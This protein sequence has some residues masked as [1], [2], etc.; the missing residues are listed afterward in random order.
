MAENSIRGQVT[1]NHAPANIF[2][3]YN[4]TVYEYIG[5]HILPRPDPRQYRTP[6]HKIKQDVDGSMHVQ[7][8]HNKIECISSLC[9][10]WEWKMCISFVPICWNRKCRFHAR[11]SLTATHILLPPVH[12]PVRAIYS[13]K[14]KMFSMW[15][16]RKSKRNAT[17]T[18]RYMFV[19]SVDDYLHATCILREKQPP[20]GHIN[21]WIGYC[22]GMVLLLMSNIIQNA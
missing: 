6:P 9:S 18:I 10:I 2:W 4:A 11:R 8:G 16:N 21:Y 1:Y 3:N 7:N 19:C 12:L 15:E 20:Q 14:W 13:Y 22:D 17:T 5:R